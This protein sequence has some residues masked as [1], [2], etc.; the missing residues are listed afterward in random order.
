MSYSHKGGDVLFAQSG[1]GGLCAWR[2]KSCLRGVF[3]SSLESLLDHRWHRPTRRGRHAPTFVAVRI[4]LLGSRAVRTAFAGFGRCEG[5]LA[6]NGRSLASSPSLRAIPADNSSQ[7]PI[8]ANAVLTGVILSK[9]R[10]RCGRSQQI[11]SAERAISANLPTASIPNK[12]YPL[13]GESQQILPCCD[14]SWQAYPR[15]G[16]F[17]HR[18]LRDGGGRGQ[19]LPPS[20]REDVGRRHQL[21]DLHVYPQLLSVAKQRFAKSEE[22]RQTRAF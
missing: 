3:G 18:P 9:R 10:P 16:W 8:P 22:Y 21:E 6:G 7:R 11:P 2:G 12:R 17:R 14:R 5:C 15:G 20:G 13:C 4:R 19:G 1:G